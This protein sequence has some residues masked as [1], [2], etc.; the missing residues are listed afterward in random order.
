MVKKLLGL[1]LSRYKI[2]QILRVTER[3]CNFR[4][5]FED[6]EPCI[7]LDLFDFLGDATLENP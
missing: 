3:L 2:L 1:G 5:E 6:A 7:Q 4:G